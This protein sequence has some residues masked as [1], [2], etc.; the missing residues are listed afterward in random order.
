VSHYIIYIIFSPVVGSLGSLDDLE[1]QII[2]DGG[3][4]APLS[5]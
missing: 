3:A 5:F 1:K 4:L 2:I